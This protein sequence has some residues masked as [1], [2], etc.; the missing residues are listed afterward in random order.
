ML[1][2]P[3]TAAPAATLLFDCTVTAESLSSATRLRQPSLPVSVQTFVAD[4]GQP[5]KFPTALKKPHKSAS[6]AETTT[7][8]GWVADQT[9]RGLEKSAAWNPSNFC[10]NL[11]FWRDLF[12][13]RIRIRK[14]ATVLPLDGQNVHA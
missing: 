7:Y 12:H 8:S 4:A 3:D 1:T 5:A 9:T 11:A 14:N 13:I 6:P 2:T 10:T